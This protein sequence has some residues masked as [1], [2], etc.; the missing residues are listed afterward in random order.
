MRFT[1]RHVTAPGH[2]LRHLHPICQEGMNTTEVALPLGPYA[3]GRN[4]LETM[5]TPL[6]MI[7]HYRYCCIVLT[8]ADPMLRDL[9]RIPYIKEQVQGICPTLDPITEFTPV[10]LLRLVSR[11]TSSFWALYKS[12]GV[13]VRVLT[14][15]LMDDAKDPYGAQVNPAI[16]SS[17]LQATWL[18]VVQD[19][20]ARYFTDHMFHVEDHGFSRT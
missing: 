19:L 17:P 2:E 12:Y 7:F 4:P 13:S 3:P 20:L 6:L 5:L 18:Y 1:G 10:K 14:Y 9:C 8:T 15:P 16:C 11:I